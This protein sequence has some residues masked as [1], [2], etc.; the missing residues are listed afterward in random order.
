[1]A[2][3]AHLIEKGIPASIR[4]AEHP[5]GKMIASMAAT[6]IHAL[7]ESDN[8]TV[9]GM[10][11]DVHKALERWN[12]EV[13]VPHIAQEDEDWGALKAKA[14][15]APEPLKPHEIAA[16]HFD[17]AM[18]ETA[19]DA[20]MEHAMTVLPSLDVDGRNHV[21]AA[22]K[23]YHKRLPAESVEVVAAP[24]PV[25]IEPATSGATGIVIGEFIPTH[26]NTSGAYDEWTFDATWLEGSGKGRLRFTPKGEH[27]FYTT[28]DSGKYRESGGANDAKASVTKVVELAVSGD[29]DVTAFPAFVPTRDKR[30]P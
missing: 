3:T 17:A 30:E 14:A 19:Y 22:M 9:N 23:R 21:N 29:Y 11:T 6:I 26:K 24:E 13:F 15:L 8:M 7:N 12:T 5:D 1:M 18:D 16:N 20:A 4:N 27:R 2:S 28:F 25:A 10:M